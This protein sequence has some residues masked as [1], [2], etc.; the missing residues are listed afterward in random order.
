MLSKCLGIK[1]NLLQ[2]PASDLANLN[3]W[4]WLLSLYHAKL[5]PPHHFS[6][7]RC[8]HLE[9]PSTLLCVWLLCHSGLSS[10]DTLSGSPPWSTQSLP[11]L[12]FD[13]L[14]HHLFYQFI[15]SPDN[16]PGVLCLLSWMFFVLFPYHHHQDVRSGRHGLC[17]SCSLSYPQWPLRHSQ[18]WEAFVGIQ[19]QTW[20][21]N[22]M[23]W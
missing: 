6:T 10:N 1:L 11:D 22:Q 9:P 16:Y 19:Q 13:S 8:P 12:P 3:S 7:Y 23:N 18:H 17:M 5:S 14:L 4:H 21:N 15:H 2:H 20:K